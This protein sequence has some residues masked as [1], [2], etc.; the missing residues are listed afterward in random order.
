MAIDRATTNVTTT[1]KAAQV[2]QPAFWYR[3]DNEDST[4]ILSFL[5]IKIR[6]PL[7]SQNRVV[8]P[9]HQY[10]Y[11]EYVHRSYSVNGIQFRTIRHIPE[12]SVPLLRQNGC[13]KTVAAKQLR[14][15]RFLRSDSQFRS[16]VSVCENGSVGGR[17]TSLITPG[18][19]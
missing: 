13:G 15:N 6:D 7:R 14:Q 8:Y 2:S 3:S 18:W 11:R 10:H 1:V 9:H 12:A 17:G 5:K 19:H 4:D 16:K